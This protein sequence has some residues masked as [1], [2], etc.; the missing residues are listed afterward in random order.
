V[1]APASRLD[2]KCLAKTVVLATVVGLLTGFFGVGGGFVIVPA[3]VLGLGFEMAAAVG[4]SLVVIAINSAVALVTRLHTGVT[5]DWPLLA[6]FTV[7]A[8]AGTLV[9]GRIVARAHPRR[10][11]TGFAAL[12]VVLAVF[13]VVRNLPPLL[14]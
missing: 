1:T 13:L 11:S 5:L 3:L 4:T 2:P 8:A 14:G 12:L 10:L 9:G 6:V 7:A